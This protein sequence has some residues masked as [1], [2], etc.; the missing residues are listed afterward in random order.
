M[1]YLVLAL[2][3]LV[4][5]CATSGGGNGEIAIETVSNGQAVEGANCA[6]STA[7]GNWNVTTPAV[8]PVG[9]PNG[10]LRVICIRPGFRTSEVVYRPTGGYAPNVGIGV[11][12]GSGNVGV[13][14]GLG[15]PI[16]F[17]GGYPPRVTVEM[18]PQ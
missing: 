12:G 15:F 7:T 11:G 1:R 2:P 4:G 8:A 9:S 10:D 6:V 18:T 14:L 13:G 5:A 16:G 17:G 3:L